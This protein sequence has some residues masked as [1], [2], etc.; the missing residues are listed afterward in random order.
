MTEKFLDLY[1]RFRFQELVLIPHYGGMPRWQ[2]IR[3]QELFAREIMPVL[4]EE[5]DPVAEAAQ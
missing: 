1:D 4:R 3:N 2:A 5:I